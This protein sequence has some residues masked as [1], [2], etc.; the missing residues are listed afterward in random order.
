M[1]TAEQKADEVKREVAYRR[2]VYARLVE[3]GKM[4]QTAA[5]E[6]IAIMVEIEADYRGQ[7]A[8]AEPGLF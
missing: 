7:V 4:K 6:R 2:R 8:A 5:S 1:F 3:E